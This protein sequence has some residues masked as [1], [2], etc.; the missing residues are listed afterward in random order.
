MSE[1][2]LDRY[3]AAHDGIV[4]AVDQAHPALSEDLPDLVAA[5]SCLGE[6]GLSMA[7][8]GI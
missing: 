6:A 4:G 3:F 2:G 7:H 8:Q 5:C 1:D